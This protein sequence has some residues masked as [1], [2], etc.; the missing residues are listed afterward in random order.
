MTT[1]NATTLEQL[2]EQSISKYKNTVSGY[3]SHAETCPK[4]LRAIGKMVVGAVVAVPVVY[5]TQIIDTYIE[6]ASKGYIYHP[7]GTLPLGNAGSVQIYFFKPEIPID[8]NGAEVRV[9][10]VQYQCDEILKIVTEVEQSYR[11][12]CKAADAAAVLA[13]QQRIQTEIEAMVDAEIELER[14][15]RIDAAKADRLARI[16]AAATA[17]PATKKARS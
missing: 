14:Q 2:K 4:T 10:G 1:F 12:E 11:A 16:A 13:E 3:D 9:T 6:Y 8:L 7:H 5:Q 15:A 17:K